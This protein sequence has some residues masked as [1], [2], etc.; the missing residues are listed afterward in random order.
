MAARRAGAST[1]RH[2]VRAARSAQRAR[3]TNYVRWEMEE[4][5]CF[6]SYHFPGRANTIRTRGRA[7]FRCTPSTRRAGRARRR[8]RCRHLYTHAAAAEHPIHRLPPSDPSSRH[9]LAQQ[10]HRRCPA[11]AGHPR[12]APHS[13]PSRAV[14]PGL[15]RSHRGARLV[16]QSQRNA[17]TERTLHTQRTLMA[18]RRTHSGSSRRGPRLSLCSRR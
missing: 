8:R 6:N 1:A 18:R 11:S 12:R 13:F 2:R 4:V 15:R 3:P 17:Q 16:A 10:R 14:D 7:Q 9:A 5:V